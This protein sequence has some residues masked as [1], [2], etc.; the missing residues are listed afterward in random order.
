MNGMMQNRHTARAVQSVVSSDGHTVPGRRPDIDGL[1]SIAILPVVLY[2]AG[3]PPFVSGFVGVDIFLVIS[4]FLIGGIVQGDLAGG[5][6]SL[7]DFY[8]RRLR[9]V[10]PALVVMILAVMVVATA[11]MS[12]R[13]LQL[14][15]IAGIS[16]ILGFGNIYFWWSTNYFATALN[17]SPFLMTWSLGLEE[18][19]YLTFPIAMVACHRFFP[20]RMGVMVAASTLVSFLLCIILISH[21]P[22]ATFYLL[23]TR[24]WELGAGVMLASIHAKSA[25]RTS[26]RFDDAAGMV[27][28]ACL[29]GAC[30]WTPIEPFPGVATLVP[31]GATLALLHCHKGWVNRRLLS[32]APFVGLGLISYSWYL[33]H[34]P[35]LELV[36]LVH[37]GHPSLT[38]TL[39]AVSISLILAWLSWRYVETPWRHGDRKSQRSL[40]QYATVV[41][42]ATVVLAIIVGLSGLPQRL[43]A[44]A[45][46]AETAMV[47]ARGNPCLTPFGQSTVG[48]DARCVQS[49]VSDRRTIALLGDSHAAA[50]GPAM[51]DMANNHQISL[52]QFEKAACSPLL[53]VEQAKAGQPEHGRQCR[54]F[55]ENVFRRLATDPQV[56]TVILASFWSASSL[57][58]ERPAPTI[59]SQTDS[60]VTTRMDLRAALIGTI[61]R[62][63]A[64]GKKVVLVEDVP[65]FLFDPGKEALSDL[66]P[67]RRL[68]RHWF[69][70]PADVAQGIAS[71]HWVRAPASADHIV[72]RAAG[73]VPGTRYISLRDGL[74][75]RHGCTYAAAT[76]EPYFVDFHHL[77]RAGASR[78]LS[79]T[80][81]Y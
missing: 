41:V 55:N 61:R 38:A 47:A 11:L 51:A 5:R 24:L 81:F 20:R 17:N 29:V 42:S 76:G 37:F 27:A 54:Q 65:L 23:P 30:I 6:F 33:W 10:L 62:Y 12:G 72:E 22:S 43:P 7:L 2:H 14:L 1:R 26:R 59:N 21:Y 67:L 63:V 58:D 19:F 40:R 56:D 78:A 70:V 44:A 34:M 48:A 53:D 25:L 16:A 36:E 18:Q 79:G 4:G 71:N 77:S 45:R 15:A 32:S 73:M 52:L 13:E 68:L 50:I 46:R 57:R 39:L 35:M 49:D 66:I 28:L 9:R 31:V 69:G 60:A 74:C 80:R 8:A 64:A 3:L 75:D